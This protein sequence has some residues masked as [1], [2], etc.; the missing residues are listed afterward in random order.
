MRSPAGCR[1]PAGIPAA[2]A[3]PRGS[4]AGSRRRAGDAPAP[5][6]RPG[7]RAGTRQHGGSCWEGWFSLLVQDSRCSLHKRGAMVTPPTGARWH[8]EEGQLGDTGL[9][10]QGKEGWRSD[11]PK[12][13]LGRCRLKSQPL[14]EPRVC[15]RGQGAGGAPQLR[16]AGQGQRGRSSQPAAQQVRRVLSTLPERKHSSSAAHEPVGSREPAAPA[17][18]GAA[19]GGGRSLLTPHKPGEASARR[20]VSPRAGRAP[21]WHFTFLFQLPTCEVVM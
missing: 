8:R 6:E 2:A 3:P 11:T 1:S 7:C 14:R 9:G 13:E 4:G 16:A 20:S 18:I 5:G 21:C 10:G 19:A 15:R 12:K 17:W